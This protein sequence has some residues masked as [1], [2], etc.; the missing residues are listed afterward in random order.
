MVGVLSSR[1]LGLVREVLQ[2]FV[3]G[4]GAAA[5][6]LAVAFRGPNLVQNLLGEQALS[7][8]FI[9]IYSRFL[10]E[11]RTLEAR[12]F[13]GAVLGVLALTAAGLALG[14]IALARL[15]V[16]ALAPGFADD[17][18]R[19]ET[20]VSAVRL[21]FPMTAVLV[22]SA[23]CLAV[24]NS[25]RR[26]FLPYF[27]P[28]LWNSSVVGALAWLATLEGAGSDVRRVVLVVS[29][30]AL[31][32]GLLQFVVQLPA[33]LR[34]VGGLD[35]RPSL[36]APGMRPA[37]RAFGPA[38]LGRGVVQLSGWLDLFLASWLATGA[39][40]ALSYA[41][42]L[43]SLPLAL[44]GTSFAVV[45][46]PEMSRLHGKEAE[47]ERRLAGSFAAA[48]F[49]TVPAAIGLVGFGLP[50]VRAVY[51]RGRFGSDAAWLVYAVLAAYACGLLPSVGS[52]LL[53]NVFLASGDTR[54]PAAVALGRVLLAAGV[55]AG[56]MLWLDRFLVHELV[57]SAASPGG[58]GDARAG[59][60]GL[61]V[62]SALGAWLELWALHGLLVRRALPAALPWGRVGRATLLSL[63]AA[64][65]TAALW[66][67]LRSWAPILLA[68]ALVG[69]FA[70]VYLGVGIWRRLAEA[71]ALVAQIGALLGRR[72]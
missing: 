60:V 21:V 44:F 64:V 67:L 43:H 17:P 47:R 61:A 71:K 58:E 15:L 69:A 8:A 72:D 27:A 25:H 3:A 38:L 24:L 19:F 36:E 40:A 41:Q 33:T 30:A 5:D 53:Q 28:V 11:G 1:L 20:A 34:L 6:V 49:L 29:A 46:L 68:P 65:P 56:A 45:E 50:I 13:A 12:R 32:G 55:G 16:A 4:T 54:T 31:V 48:S 39:L 26:F 14:G 10:A 23:W 51:E 9:P 37:L 42:R 57:R 35:P 63:L 70:S 62:G 22:L 7:A 59:A 66:W 52:R 18:V 2:A